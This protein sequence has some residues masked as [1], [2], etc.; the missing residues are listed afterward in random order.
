MAP[1]IS[2]TEP[3]LLRRLL[4]DAARAAPPPPP[5]PPVPAAAAPVVSTGTPAEPPEPS[6]PPYS[7][8]GGSIEE[9]VANLINWLLRVR[10]V[11]G[12]F[13]ADANG[14]AIAN[15]GVD[16]DH[17]A[18]CAT[19]MDT[20]GTVRANLASDARR[21]ALTIAKGQ[22][23]HLVAVETSWG[24]FGVGLVSP[25]FLSD[26]FMARAQRALSMTLG[27]DQDGE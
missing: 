20:L 22:V 19:L 23:L 11:D 8:E 26:E 12:I 18:I 25:D 16:T 2:W 27:E 24:A 3:E 10:D 14:L 9:R 7:V 15:H 1:S 5:P 21:M 4:E 17:I 6:L 13:I